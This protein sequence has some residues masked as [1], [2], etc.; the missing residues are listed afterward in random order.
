MATLTTMRR[1]SILGLAINFPSFAR[2]MAPSMYRRLGKVKVFMFVHVYQLNTNH[3]PD[4][5]RE[6]HKCLMRLSIGYLPTLNYAYY[7]DVF[8]S[9]WTTIGSE[10]LVQVDCPCV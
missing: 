6:I 9:D 3:E 10:L 8:E 7:H 1:R 4:F 5:G 2:P